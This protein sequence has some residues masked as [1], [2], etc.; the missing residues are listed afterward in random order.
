MILELTGKDSF[1]NDHTLARRHYLLEGRAF[2]ILAKAFSD[3]DGI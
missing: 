2:D 1:G 3:D